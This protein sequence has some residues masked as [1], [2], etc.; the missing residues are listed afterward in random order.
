MIPSHFERFMQFVLAHTQNGDLQWG[1]GEGGSFVASHEDITLIISSDYDPDRDINT[2]W[3]RLNGSTRS[4]PFSVSE[5]EQGYGLM[6]GIFEEVTANANDVKSDMEK[7]MAGFSR[8]T[9]V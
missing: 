4:T 2:F 9:E 8:G 3:F 6:K 7:F 1:I 5:K